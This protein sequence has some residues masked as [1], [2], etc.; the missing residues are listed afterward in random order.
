[1]LSIVLVVL[2]SVVYAQSWGYSSNRIAISADGNSEPDNGH[3]WP[4][5]DPDD[6]GATPATLAILAKLQ[7]QNK[8]VHYSYNNFIEAPAGPDEKNQMKIGAD[9]A[10][11]RWGFDGKLFFD[12]TRDPAAAR[13]HLKAE[14][15]KSTAENRLYFIHMGPAE[16]FYQV[17]KEVV[18]EDHGAALAH[19]Y[20]V[21]HSG[22]NDTHLR[23]NTHHTIPQAIEY[24]KNLLKYRKIK[25]QNGEWDPNVLWNSKADFSPWYW[26]R[27][28]SDP[29]MK[30]L[31]E[32]MRAHAYGKADISDAGMVFWLLLGDEDGSPSKFKRFIGNGIPTNTE[33]L[34]R[35][36]AGYRW[37]SIEILSDEFNG[38]SLDKSKWIPRHPYWSGR[39]SRHEKSNVSVADGKLRLKSTLREGAGEI[40]A[41]TVT[42]ACVTSRYRNC[43]TGYYE[44]RIKA[45]DLSMTTA[46]WFQG[47][48]SEIDVIENIG[49]ASLEE[50]RWID[51]TMMINTHFFRSGWKKDI[52]TPRKWKMPTRAR[53]RFHTYGMWW[54]DANTTWFY[55][56]GVKVAEITHGGAFDEP[57]YMFFDTEVFTWHGW[58]TKES[59]L[60]PK[61]NTMLVDWVRAWKLEKLQQ[62]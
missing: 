47:K 44:A 13:N 12:V 56:D 3:K 61:R 37:S 29:N 50:N 45:S 31:Y 58:P 59:L 17:V 18:D 46:F 21:S 48:Y 26:L 28:H 2:P 8:L 33:W 11:R 27:D 6:W 25:D 54:K 7:M 23:R 22:Y 52:A 36:P 60:D 57:Q 53:D 14:L 43:T 41:S 1:M 40:K 62:K 16:F 51:D 42:A 49:R 15:T 19:V 34:P 38:N 32:R 35:P 55:H 20:I 24:S 4:T 39:N 9:G 30:W 10:I 5:G